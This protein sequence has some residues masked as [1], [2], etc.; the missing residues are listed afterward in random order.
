MVGGWVTQLVECVLSLCEALGS[1]QN[2][3]S[4]LIA[5]KVQWHI[6]EFLAIQEGEA[7]V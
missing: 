1:I 5:S 6:L 2:K 7:S 3:N 4:M